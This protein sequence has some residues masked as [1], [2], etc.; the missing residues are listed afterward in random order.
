MLV[1]VAVVLVAAEELLVPEVVAAAALAVQI[2][3]M[4]HQAQ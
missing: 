2:L 4:A 3:Q 1:A